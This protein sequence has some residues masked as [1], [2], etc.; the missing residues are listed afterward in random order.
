MR[1]SRRVP[2]V[3]LVVVV[4]AALFLPARAADP[5]PALNVLQFY[6]GGH[7]GANDY[8][9]G[10]TRDA[11]R[12][13][14][15][16]VCFRMKDLSK[17][18][19]LGTSTIEVLILV[20]VSVTAERDMRIMRQAVAMWDGGIHYLAPRMGLPWLSQVKFHVTFDFV[21]TAV[22]GG[23]GLLAPPVIA[24][25]IVVVGVNPSAG[26]GAG[27]DPLN[28][29][30]LGGLP[31]G[32]VPCPTVQRPFD[33]SFWQGLKGFTSRHDPRSGTYEASCGSQDGQG[34]HHV[35]FVVDGAQDP[36][37][38]SVDWFGSFWVTSHEFGHCL[39]LG[40]VGDGAEGSVNGVWWGPVPFQEI[41]NYEGYGDP[42]S[43][44]G[45]TPAFN[46][47]A[48]TLDVETFAARMSH[49]LDTNGDGVVNAK[50][51]LLTNDQIGVDHF[52]MQ[53]MNPAD[54]SYASSTG[55]AKDCPQPDLGLLPG[56]PS[57]VTAEHWM[58]QPAPGVAP[59]LDL[60]GPDSGVTTRDSSV[61][62]SGSVSEH[63]LFAPHVPA[64]T[65]AT[66]ADPTGDAKSSF[67]DITSVT[68]AATGTDVD[69]VINVGQVY[70]V[71]PG[72][73]FSY[74]L[75]INGMRFDS[76]VVDQKKQAPTPLLS[77]G[78]EYVGSTEWD[79]ANNRILIH[80][81]RSILRRFAIAAPYAIS[82]IANNAGSIET[83]VHDDWAPAAGGTF[84]IAAPP[85]KL[86]PTVDNPSS[87]DDLDGVPDASDACPLQPGLLANGCSPAPTTTVRITR[88]GLVVGSQ[89]VYAH[90]G[91]GSFAIPVD[92][93]D[94][95]QT[96]R[97]EWLA[98]TRVLATRDILVTKRKGRGDG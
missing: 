64:G 1:P 75:V 10:C 89:N 65:T 47:C 82:A 32:A 90:H 9:V 41:M 84:G 83:A 37:P 38:T 76:L 95:H 46:K 20:P 67:T 62:V 25:D 54:Y 43:E 63:S 14:P 80:V 72:T 88:D 68:A 81:P 29:T 53:V 17:L 74:S 97:V 71:G 70:P 42:R 13:N 36:D 61:V 60:T 34:T 40:H 4:M 28:S 55:L 8:P 57:A 3:G 2:L 15:A 69:A 45:G 16:N 5:A 18:N 44:T 31:L 35:C 91:P 86:P 93:V 73:T 56:D 58:P 96:L 19:P 27:L 24:P 51:V 79:V 22:N 39:T 7:L 94:G 21:N 33:L 77:D 92:L 48:S 23:G 50:D 30:P 66:V 49:F 11:N 87:D 6:E 98:G 12:D 59:E 52:P 78:W 26:V 85:E